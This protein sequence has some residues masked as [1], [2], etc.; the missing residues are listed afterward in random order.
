LVADRACGL[1]DKVHRAEERP[2]LPGK[3]NIAGIVPETTRRLCDT[4]VTTELLS[5]L[6]SQQFEALIAVL[7]RRQGFKTWLTG[8]SDAGVDV[9]AIAEG[10]R[11]GIL[12]QCKSSADDEKELGWEGVRDVTGG[13]M[14]YQQSSPGIAF[15]RIA[16]TNQAFKSYARERARASHVELVERVQLIELL[17]RH[18]VGNLELDRVLAEPRFDIG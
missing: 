12:L 5:R 17:D 7:W 15:R 2:N 9:V 6:E 18:P 14:V 8:K 10:G 4:P 13:F 16:A 3:F 1:Q 11:E